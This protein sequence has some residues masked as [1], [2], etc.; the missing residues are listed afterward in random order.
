VNEV[1]KGPLGELF[2]QRQL[3]TDVSG[4]GNN[5][6]HGHHVYG[7]QVGALDGRGMQHR[8]TFVYVC[9]CVHA[10]VVDIWVSIKCGSRY[11][12]AYMI[13]MCC[14]CMSACFMHARLIF[15][16]IYVITVFYL[17]MCV[18]VCVCV[19]VRARACVSVCVCVFGGRQIV[20]PPL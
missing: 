15:K 13:W 11:I 9:V 19:C 7:P 3:L 8:M 5:W 1:L 10:I 2:D 4:S 14:T 12:C 6:A 18:C 20:S 17:L 16:S